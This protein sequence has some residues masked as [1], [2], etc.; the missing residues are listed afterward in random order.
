[1]KASIQNPCKPASI[2]SWQL[3]E[4]YSPE[5]LLTEK[6][7]L[8]YLRISRRQLYE[9]RMKGLIPYIKLGKAVR[10]RRPDVDRVLDARTIHNNSQEG[11]S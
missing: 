4:S 11:Q 1:M 8:E 6:E 2:G 5:P 10:F 9:W 7:V 3:L